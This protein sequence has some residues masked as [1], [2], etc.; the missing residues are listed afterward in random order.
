MLAILRELIS[1][2]RE[3]YFGRL[4]ASMTVM[5][6]LSISPF[7]AILLSIS[8]A[9]G[10]L[11]EYLERLRPV[12]LEFLATGVGNELIEGM[13]NAIANFRAQTLG[14]VAFGFLL[15][16]SMR[17]IHEVDASVKT[18]WGEK[19]KRA[20]WGKLLIYGLVLFVG[21]LLLSVALG[22]MD[23]GALAAL[24]KA[25]GGG[26]LWLLVASGLFL[27]YYFGPVSR[28]TAVYAFASALI[29][30]GLLL[31]AQRAFTF[32]SK[33]LL[34][35]NEIYGSL[36]ILPLFLMWVMILWY[37]FL[38]GVALTKSLCQ[39]QADSSEESA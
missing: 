32:S 12:L 10:Q 36:A 23:Y 21:P 38:L 20:W 7:L 13:N 1:I 8:K 9:Y 39:A 5:T 28:P 29:T 31:A 25:L 4:V 34:R 27:I 14:S 24:R 16:T 18:I 11:G 26:F 33:N 19:S 6:T 17:L 2:L 30:S 3:P 22:L 37:I 15:V 35:H